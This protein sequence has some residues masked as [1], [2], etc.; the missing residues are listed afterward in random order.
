MVVT[1]LEEGVFEIGHKKRISELNKGKESMA[2][3][4]ESV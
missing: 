1:R 4:V 3:L 2:A